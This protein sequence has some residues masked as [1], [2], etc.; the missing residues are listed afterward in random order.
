MSRTHT[1]THGHLDSLGSCRSQKPVLGL[2]IVERQVLYHFWYDGRLNILS[3]WS[4][5]WCA[6]AVG[7]SLLNRQTKLSVMWGG[8]SEW[9]G[10]RS[11]W[12]LSTIRHQ[13]TQPWN[14]WTIAVC[15]GEFR[16]K[17]KNW[18]LIKFAKQLNFKATIPAYHLLECNGWKDSCDSF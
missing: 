6:G 9:W 17:K 16:R 10:L 1:R 5:Q 13:Q 7:V 4:C 2:D 3:L 12:V 15:E 11:E 18:Y 14:L 8:E